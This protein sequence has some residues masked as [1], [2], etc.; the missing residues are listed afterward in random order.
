MIKEEAD[1][2]IRK[3][4]D[5][6]KNRNHKNLESTKGSDFV[7]SYVYLLYYK[8]QKIN[9]NRN[10]SNIDSLLIAWKTKKATENLIKKKITNA[11][12]TLLQLH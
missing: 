3:L 2:V 10:G 1:K 9:L 4:F 7:F 5:S 6:L 8:C 12:K 11:S